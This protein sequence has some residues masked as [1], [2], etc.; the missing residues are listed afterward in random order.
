M[1][2]KKGGIDPDY[3]LNRVKELKDQVD[4]ESGDLGHAPIRISNP[5]PSIVRGADQ[6]YVVGQSVGLE[7]DVIS[8][9]PPVVPDEFNELFDDWKPGVSPDTANLINHYK[10]ENNGTDDGSDGADLV[11]GGG[12]SATF[13]TSPTPLNDSYSVL[14]DLDA[15][16]TS[17]NGF[18]T[19]GTG[20]SWDWGT[21]DR[22][23]IFWIQQ[24]A[25]TANRLVMCDGSDRPFTNGQ[26]G[27][28]CRFDNGAA[29]ALVTYESEVAKI[30]TNWPLSVGHQITHVPPTNTWLMYALTFDNSSGRLKLYRG[31]ASFLQLRDE[32]QAAGQNVTNGRTG[33]TRAA[34]HTMRDTA[35]TGNNRYRYGSDN[36]YIDNTRIYDRVLTTEELFYIWKEIRDGNVGT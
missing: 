20:G 35:Y 26:Q 36:L 32:V 34:F 22:T 25:A 31:G 2:R 14:G 28:W 24:T 29:L 15:T 1:V 4:Y 10:F 12:G 11:Q 33:Q 30:N 16:T 3:T 5:P 27:W 19:T 18:L 6:A 23:I 8:P 7:S 21:E 13:E 9:P 17:N